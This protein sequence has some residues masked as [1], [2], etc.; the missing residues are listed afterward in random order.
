MHARKTLATCALVLG[1][2]APLGAFAQTVDIKALDPDNDGT[3]SLDEATKAGAS[4]FDKLDGDHDGTIDKKEAAGVIPEKMFDR[5]DKD[6]D[7]TI[8]KTEYGNAVA[9]LFKHAD[10]DKDGTLDAAELSKG[11]GKRLAT[12]I[13]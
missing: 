2:C 12:M 7:G 10:K 11:P 4:R 9:A 6:K 13:Q 5:I 1:L 8:D 3:V